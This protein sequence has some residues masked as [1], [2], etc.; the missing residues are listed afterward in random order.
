M[1]GLSQDERDTLKK[2]NDVQHMVSLG[3]RVRNI[4]T[5]PTGEGKIFC[6]E[7]GLWDIMNTQPILVLLHGYPQTSFMCIVT[8]LPRNI[9]L[10]IP[11]LPGYGRSS[12]LSGPHNKRSVGQAIL[13]A[14]YSLLKQA[15][16]RTYKHLRLRH[17]DRKPIVIGGHDEGARVCH[18]LAVD[19]A[20]YPT[21]SFQGAIL[22]NIVPTAIQWY[23]FWTAEAAVRSF[24]WSFLANVEVATEM[25]MAQGGDAFARV[26]LSRWVGNTAL[27]L[28]NFMSQDSIAIYTDSFK[29]ESVIRATCDGFRAN[30]EEDFRLQWEDQNSGKKM[31]VEVLLLYTEELDNRFNVYPV[32]Q[33][34]MGKSHNLRGSMCQTLAG[35]HIGH[36][37][38]EEAPH[39]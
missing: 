4:P 8:C 14:L 25:I 39:G 18:R 11:D 6:Y 23:T 34:F 36:F 3:L 20:D 24:H 26:C 5:G 28:T 38:P 32:W 1:L 7:R 37:L 12:P 35:R 9:P 21:F 22:F 29:S 30:A 13:K 17:A 31:D 10:F 16:N 19:Q 33:D 27:G 15:N 2:D